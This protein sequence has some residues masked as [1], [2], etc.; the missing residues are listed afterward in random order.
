MNKLRNLGVFSEAEYKGLTIE[1]AT[2][3]AED[4]GFT[5]RIVER[6]GEYFMLDTS[7]R[8]DRINFRVRNDLVTAAFGG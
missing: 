1:E 4:G 6:D 7:A 2:K 3:Y 5:T 8:A